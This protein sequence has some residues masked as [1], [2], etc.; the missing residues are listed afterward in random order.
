MALQYILIQHGSQEG[1]S[2]F[3]DLSIDKVQDRPY[4]MVIPSLFPFLKYRISMLYT[5]LAS[6]M[7]IYPYQGPLIETE[8]IFTCR[9]SI[10]IK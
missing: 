4:I 10:T 3:Q 2:L 9:K 5:G 1:T 7:I 6:A 8:E